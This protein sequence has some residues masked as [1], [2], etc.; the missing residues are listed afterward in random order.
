VPQR[1]LSEDAVVVTRWNKAAQSFDIV[2]ERRG[3]PTP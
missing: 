1:G 3:I 2:S